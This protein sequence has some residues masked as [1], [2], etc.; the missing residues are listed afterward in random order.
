MSYDWE[1][2]LLFHISP[3]VEDIVIQDTSIYAQGSQHATNLS[4]QGVDNSIH[5]EAHIESMNIHPTSGGVAPLYSPLNPSFRRVW[6]RQSTGP[7]K[8][9][10]SV[11]CRRTLMVSNLERSV[12]GGLS[13]R[14]GR[15][16]GCPTTT[17]S[18]QHLKLRSGLV[19]ESFAM[20]EKTP[21]TKPL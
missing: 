11:V 20:P 15:A 9:D 8:C 4:A 13:G 1:L 18:T 6:R 7:L 10:L 17:V 14:A 5:S 16:H 19:P 3:W 2:L 21:P 12:R